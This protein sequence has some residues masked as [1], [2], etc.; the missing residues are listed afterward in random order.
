MPLSRCGIT[1][2]CYICMNGD[3]QCGADKMKATNLHGPPIHYRASIFGPFCTH[4]SG[5]VSV[6]CYKIFI[7]NILAATNCY[8]INWYMFWLVCVW[9]KALDLIVWGIRRNQCA[10]KRHER[11]C[12]TV[13]R[14]RS[15][16][17]NSMESRL[18]MPA[19]EKH[20]SNAFIIS[21]CDGRWWK[22]QDSLF[23]KGGHR[24]WWESCFVVFI[25]WH[26]NKGVDLF[27]VIC[28]HH[29][30]TVRPIHEKISIRDHQFYSALRKL[31]PPRAPIINVE[32]VQPQDARPLNRRSPR[33]FIIND[34]LLLLVY[35]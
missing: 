7:T 24:K 32:L 29:N 28:N 4:D 35:I 21:Q 26:S 31:Y 10:K 12:S 15:T 6:V 34:K 30:T 19:E 1:L 23:D 2:I 9:G 3:C 18:W 5:C 16:D 25:N 33:H 20:S 17:S 13:S 22:G 8:L 27:S 11:T 14:R